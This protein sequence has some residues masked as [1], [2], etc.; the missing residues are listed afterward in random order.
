MRFEEGSPY[1]Y[2]HDLVP[3]ADLADNSPEEVREL[4]RARVES[5][6]DSDSSDYQKIERYF[7]L[8]AFHRS[9]A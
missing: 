5:F 8:L 7:E 6:L 3:Q 1:F 9:P 2:R 4:T